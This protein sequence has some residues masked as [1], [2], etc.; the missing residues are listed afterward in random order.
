MDD[1]GSDSDATMA[2]SAMEDNEEEDGER[3]G[4]DEL[5]KYDSALLLQKKQ[6]LLS[7]KF[8][9]SAISTSV[10]NGEHPKVSPHC[11]AY[12]GILKRGFH[13]S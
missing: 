13:F 3:E 7:E 10:Q 1:I 12:A 11:R 2:D 9:R 8:E 5:V 6:K 4:E